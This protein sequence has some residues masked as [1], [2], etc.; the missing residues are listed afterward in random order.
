MNK[1]KRLWIRITKPALYGAILEVERLQN[2]IAIKKR[3]HE[4]YSHLQKQ[5]YDA[6]ARVEV[7]GGK[8]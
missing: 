3:Y 4:K 6:R 8:K 5:L 1:L 2:K 7:L